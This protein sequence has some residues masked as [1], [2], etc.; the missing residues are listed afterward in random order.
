MAGRLGCFRAASPPPLPPVV[1]QSVAKPRT[2]P[3]TLTPL[4]GTPFDSPWVPT[5]AH[6]QYTLCF[7]SGAEE[8]AARLGDMYNVT[9]RCHP[10]GR[11]MI[12]TSFPEDRH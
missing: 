4:T 8:T 12:G 7:L 3:R 2:P 5:L 1:V 10:I 9:V 11:G 6:S